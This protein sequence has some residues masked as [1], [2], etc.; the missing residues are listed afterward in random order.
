MNSKIEIPEL[1]LTRRNT[2]IQTIFTSIFAYVFINIYKPFGSS[3]WYE[4]D[5]WQFRIYSGLLVLLG[6]V[7]VVVSRM[8]LLTMVK[9]NPVKLWPFL[10]FV[11]GEIIFM[12]ALYALFERMFLNDH[13]HFIEIWFLAV[14][15]TSLILLIPYLMSTLFF[16]WEEKKLRL[17]KILDER[18]SKNT[19]VFIPFQDENGVLRISIKK[20][21][22]I[23]LASD[24]NYVV[25]HYLMDGDE[26][27]YM[28]RN[29]LKNLEEKLLLFGIIRC[30]RSYMVNL[31]HVNLMTNEKRTINLIL[32]Q[33]LKLKVPVSKSYEENLIQALNS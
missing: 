2:T 12:G 21:D 3:T 19:P 13:R 16:M 33:P 9:R 27:K 24:D 28:L 22:V 4:V 30:H 20:E 1:L 5:N 15:N 7:V 10:L 25:I 31:Y 14:Q 32:K 23:Y 8:I 11:A 17:E 26:Q 18:K 29:T 6:M